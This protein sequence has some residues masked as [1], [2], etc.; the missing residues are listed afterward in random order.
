MQKIVLAFEGNS[1]NEKIAVHAIQ[2]AVTVAIQET[3]VIIRQFTNTEE[4]G[5]IDADEQLLV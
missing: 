3:G 1:L 2:A 5:C 4:N